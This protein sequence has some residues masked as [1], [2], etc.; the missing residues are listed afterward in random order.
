MTIA[1][2]AAMTVELAPLLRAADAVEVERR[3][4]QPIYRGRLG[5]QEVV[6]AELGMGKVRAAATLQAVLERYP[7]SAV[8]HFGSAGAV[9]PKFDVGQLIVG[10]QLIQHDFGLL[11]KRALLGWGRDW[12]K[13]DEPL[14]G[15][16]LAAGRRL[17][18]PIAL[19]RIVTGDQSIAHNETRHRLWTKFRADCVEMEGAAV[20]MVCHLNGIPFAVLRGLTDRAD[21]RAV[22]S[23][24]KRIHAVSETVAAVVA[25]CVNHAPRRASA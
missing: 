22:R 16:L 20:G 15:Q 3:L 23:F 14:S 19:G 13:A 5:G 2:L 4:Q 17:G 10:K 25:E 24:R 7:V 18:Q 9:N 8:I 1:L 11:S 6:L 21:E 12:V